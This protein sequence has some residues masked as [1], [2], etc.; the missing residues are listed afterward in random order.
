MTVQASRNV[1]LK[2]GGTPTTMTGEA[3]TEVG[4]VCTITAAAKRAIDP[5]S[6]VTVYDGV[7][8]ESATATID[9]VNG[10][11]TLAEAPAGA[12]TITGKYI[13]LLTVAEA[14]ALKV[15]R[16]QAVFADVTRLGDT[17]GRQCEVFKKCELTLTHMHAVNDDLDGGAGTT[18]LES[19]MAAGTPLFVEAALG[20]ET[21]RGW[22]SVVDEDRTHGVEA[23]VQN[24]TITLRGV[25]R[26][27]VGRPTT[28]QA[29]FSITTDAA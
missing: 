7:S 11:I 9:F 4:A 19:L 13:P 21:L 22:F 5:D 16:P 17:A 6:A 18:S 12:V 2:V 14:K 15:V 3:T 8:D 27:C 1:T 29:L 26:D 24:A 25:V 28:E 23:D 10:V 20:G